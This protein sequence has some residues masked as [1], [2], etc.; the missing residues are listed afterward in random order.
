MNVRLAWAVQW[1]HISWNTWED[2][3]A[4]THKSSNSPKCSQQQTRDLWKYALIRISNKIFLKTLLHWERQHQAIRQSTQWIKERNKAGRGLRTKFVNFIISV[5][6]HSNC[7]LLTMFGFVLICMPSGREKQS[8][9]HYT[10]QCF[11]HFL[12]TT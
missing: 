10:S 4:K 5:L 6:R 7:K 9:N 3:K 1:I 2:L 12:L 11:I 8:P